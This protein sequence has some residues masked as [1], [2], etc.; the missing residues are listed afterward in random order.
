MIARKFLKHVMSHVSRY[1]VLLNLSILNLNGD[2]LLRH[3]ICF[4]IQIYHFAEN[5]L[6]MFTMFQPY[7]VLYL[8]SY[9]Y[10]N[11]C[12]VICLISVVLDMYDK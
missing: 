3:I 7:Y 2:V 4:A 9:V 5:V 12:L 10:Q 8:S 1:F 6:I 11:M